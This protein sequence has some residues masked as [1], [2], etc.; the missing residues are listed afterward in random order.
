MLNLIQSNRMAVAENKTQKY[1]N[2]L[3]NFEMYSN[4][5]IIYELSSAQAGLHSS[6]MTWFQ[7]RA[8]ALLK[9]NLIRI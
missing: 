5:F 6:S 9:L 2:G 1:R 7:S 3:A 4:V 8:T